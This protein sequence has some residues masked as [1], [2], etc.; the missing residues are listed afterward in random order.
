[1]D[2]LIYTAMSGAKSTMAQQASVANN[3]ANVSTTGFRAELNTL[4]AVPVVSQA[5]PTRAFSV[6]ASVGNDFTSGPLEHTGSELDVAV[7]G[8]GWLAVTLPDGKEA[9]TRSGSLKI[10]ENGILRTQGGLEVAGDGGQIAI[11]PDNAVEIASDGTITAVPLTGARNAANTVGRLKLV[12]PPEDQLVRGGD[13][14][15]RLKSGEP[16]D[17]DEGVRV[18]SGYLEGSNVNMVEQMVTMISLSRNYELHIRMLQSAQEND[19]AATQVLT[20]S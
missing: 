2:K 3:L 11:P 13:G 4:R 15:F 1:M 6:D 12:N 10:D 20:M 18:G 8:K 9:Y 5:L 17:V 19:K 16:A 7:N 14:L